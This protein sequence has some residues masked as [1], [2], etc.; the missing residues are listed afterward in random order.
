MGRATITADALSKGDGGR[1][2]VWS[3]GQTEFRGNVSAQGGKHGGSG[4]YVETSGED[5]IHIGR[6]RIR[7]T[8]FDGIAGTWLIDPAGGGG[9]VVAESGGTITPETIETNLASTDEILS[10]TTTIGVFDPLVYNSA[11]DLLLLAGTNITIGASIQ[12]T[13]VS[14]GGGVYLIA[15]WDGT[16]QTVSQLTNAGVFGNNGG[17]VT[18]GGQNVGFDGQDQSADIAVGSRSG[19]TTVAGNEIDLSSG[20]FDSAN[21]QIGYNGNGGGDIVVDATGDLVVSI[22]S[23]GSGYTQIGNGDV[24]GLAGADTITGNITLDIE[25]TTRLSDTNTSGVAWIGNAHNNED[26]SSTQTGNLTIVTGDFDMESSDSFRFGDIVQNTLEG[27]S[28]PTASTG[29]DFTLALSNEVGDSAIGGL[30]QSG[31]SYNSTHTLSLVSNTNVALSGSIQ[32]GRAGD[33]NIIAG[34]NT[35]SVSPADLIANGAASIVSS[36]AYG[37]VNGDSGGDIT[38]GGNQS[39]MAIGSKGGATTVAGRNVTLDA[40]SGFV[41]VGYNGR[42]ATGDIVVDA[43]GNVVLS[44]GDDGEFAQIGHGGASSTGSE[45]GNIT[46]N[47]KGDVDL[48]GGDGFNAYA[49]IGHGGVNANTDP[50]ASFSYSGNIAVSGANVV[51]QGG[52]GGQAYTQ[53]GHGGES[54]GNDPS[55][56]ITEKNSG[57]IVVKATD[58]SVTLTAGGGNGYAQIGHGGAYTGIVFSGDPGVLPAA[59]NSGNITVSATGGSVSLTGTG[60]DAPDDQSTYAQIGHGGVSSSGSDSGDIL[61]T[62]DGDL[63]LTGGSAQPDGYGLAYAQIGNGAGSTNPQTDSGDIT[64][65]VG[66]D[67][68][69]TGSEGLSANSDYVQ[70]G[71]G[72][73]LNLNSPTGPVSGDI[74]IT[75]GGTTTLQSTQGASDIWIGNVAGSGTETGDVT[76]I[77]KDFDAFDD[78]NG[79]LAKFMA[80]DLSGGDFT[81]G[82]TDATAYGQIGAVSYSSAHDLTLLSAG[83]FLLTGSIQN[84]GSGAITVIGGWNGHTL[85]SAA[86]I[87]AAGAYGKHGNDVFIGGSGEG[88]AQGDVSVGSKHGTTTVAGNTVE[89]DAEIGTAQIGFAGKGNGDINVTARQDIDLEAF[90]GELALIGNGTKAGA[91]NVGGNITLNTLGGSVSLDAINGSLVQIGNI[92]GAGSTLSGDVSINTHG[93][94]VSVLAEEET[95]ERLPPHGVDPFIEGGPAVAHLGNGGPDTTGKISGNVSISTG[96]GNVN[97]R[98]QPD[99]SVATI[100]ALA[101]ADASEKDNITI[102][103]DSGALRIQSD[104]NGSSAQIGNW[105]RSSSSKIIGGDITIDAGDITM[106]SDGSAASSQIGNGNYLGPQLTGAM[107]GDITINAASLTMTGTAPTSG[108]FE[109]VR[110]GNLGSGPVSGTLTVNTTGDITLSQTGDGATSIGNFSNPHSID[111]STF[112]DLQG[113]ASGNLDVTAG[114]DISMA[115]TNAGAFVSMEIGGVTNGNVDITANGDV[116]L[117][118]KNSGFAFIGGYEFDNGGADISVTSQTGSVS[119][120]ATG[121]AS[122]VQIGNLENSSNTGAITGNLSVMAAKNIIAAT[123]SGTGSFVR[124]GNSGDADGSASGNTTLSAGNTLKIVDA[125]ASLI[126]NTGGS[127]SGD[128]T[129]GAKSLTGDITPSLSN[130]LPNG[131]F[132]LAL[133]GKGALALDGFSYSSSHALSISNGGD[134]TIDG[135]LQNSGAGD[136]GLA[137]GAALTTDALKTKGAIVLASKGD[138][139]IGAVNAAS[140][141]LK[142]GGAI[143]ANGAIKTTDATSLTSAGDTS[144]GAVQA[145]SLTVKSGGAID[146]N[147]AIKTS[148]ATTLASAGNTTIGGTLD[149]ASLAVAA[150]GNLGIGGVV[151]T[152]GTDGI[153]LGSGGDIVFAATVQNTGSG[154]VAVAATGDVTV[155]GASATGDVFVGSK[156]GD[157]TLVADNVTLDAK[158]GYAQLGYHGAGSGSIGVTA[159]GDVALNGGS[160]TGDYAQIGNGGYQTSGDEG[161]D[162]TVAALGDVSLNGGSGNQAYAQI[163]HGGAEADKNS[164]GYTNTGAIAVSGENV[165][166]AGGGGNASYAQIGNGGYLLGQGLKGNGV[167]S[168]DIDVIAVDDVTLAGGSANAY[169]QIGNGGGQINDAPG[170]NATASNAGDIN[171]TVSSPTGAVTMAA[172]SGDAS[173]VQIGNGGFASDAPTDADSANFTD[174]GDIFVSDLV[175]TGSDRGDNGYAQIGNGDASKNNVGNISGNITI[176]AGHVTVTNGKALNANALIGGA[177]GRGTVTGS[178]FGYNSGNGTGIAT[179]VVANL[180]QNQTSPTDS[181]DFI[182]QFPPSFWNTAASLTDRLATEEGTVNPLEQLADGDTYEGTE[183]SDKASEELGDSLNGG[184]GHH[185]P[186]TVVSKVIIPGV[187]RELVTYYPHQSHA[188]PGDEDYSS[189]GNEALWQW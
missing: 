63:E 48:E 150:G 10:T 165:V 52:T 62:T 102:D 166:L 132:T 133:T 70:I 22:G 176:A 155:G 16:T 107:S 28:T 131:D 6:V 168:G 145:A 115:A 90:D 137:S 117:A 25:G 37:R 79:D 171:V 95:D 14:N 9:I 143:D 7:T 175:L 106:L 13:K 160:H 86:H 20:A 97:L 4:G 75:V 2:A 100:G 60:D 129:I 170:A 118:S 124:I 184:H 18:I 45:G 64:L 186:A 130:D 15:G 66:G 162:I 19:I 29:G 38:F 149:A 39:G 30:L 82:T 5:G 152:S 53:I 71:N 68:T 112:T 67:L 55:V 59:K 105:E 180:I 89:F 109:E 44:A 77:T 87:I 99:G 35:N 81:L 72:S 1:V 104:G 88:G 120:Q 69:L 146:A 17:S 128:V 126:G 47:A 58:G 54:V 46:V 148:G 34:W 11:H 161:G 122:G 153:V 49:Q 151:T 172:G 127:F 65:N 31:L 21:T 98:A 158:N 179:G 138:A 110:I 183:D 76:L 92:G 187:L 51:L 80:S 159:S 42:G 40:S 61:V 114:G 33:I 135:A 23:S 125:D 8:G 101:N 36:G 173:Y 41:Q 113:E 178:V 139:S 84:A 181:P 94:A 85:G 140:L 147:G 185:K 56:A 157:L 169:A 111:G 174:S 123:N 96:G 103:T 27:G 167:N 50:S 26:P 108:G 177:T 156:H 91:G 116:T 182:T 141:A 78:E 119:A 12:N 93:G 154:D 83:S 136:I 189:W 134:L 3:K 32:N 163:G 164:T 73:V 74:D 144:L 57:N 188:A 142:S 43:K 24:Y 121:D